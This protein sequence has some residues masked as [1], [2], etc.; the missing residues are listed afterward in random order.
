[1]SVVIEQGEGA[2]FVGVA[3][4]LALRFRHAVLRVFHVLVELLLNIIVE[5]PGVALFRFDR[6]VSDS[7]QDRLHF[8]YPAF[9]EYL[10][11]LCVPSG[12]VVSARGEQGQV[13][14]V[15]G[16]GGTFGSFLE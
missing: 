12:L 13:A 6:G 2:F 14:A 8:L 9:F 16:E 3:D 4:G 7:V 15:H 5:A 11:D 10:P 1:M